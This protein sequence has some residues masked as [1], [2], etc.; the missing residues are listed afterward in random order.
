MEAEPVLSKL[1]VWLTPQ[2]QA[3]QAVLLTLLTE[4]RVQCLFDLDKELDPASEA[5]MPADIQLDDPVE[6][7]AAVSRGDLPRRPKNKRDR[8][9]EQ[10]ER[11]ARIEAEA[12]EKARAAA[13]LAA[14]LAAEQQRLAEE[15]AERQAAAEKAIKDQK[16]REAAAAQKEKKRLAKLKQDESR[17]RWRAKQKQKRLEERL[18]REQARASQAVEEVKYEKPKTRTREQSTSPL[19]SPSLDLK[20]T[21]FWPRRGRSKRREASC[22]QNA[23]RSGQQWLK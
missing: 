22:R 23:N 3:R 9:Q 1:D 15:E 10:K 13:E 11:Q 6:A 2:H 4:A 20:R 19:F 12:A 16:R 17:Q 8:L 7:D 18:A 21:H 14:Q 5:S